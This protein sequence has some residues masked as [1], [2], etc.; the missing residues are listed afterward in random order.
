[1]NYQNVWDQFFLFV[2]LRFGVYLDQIM[3]YMYNVQYIEKIQKEISLKTGLSLTELNKLPFIR[4]EGPP[5]SNLEDCLQLEIHRMTQGEFKKNNNPGGF[6]YDF[7]IENCLS[8]IFNQWDCTK[9]KLGLK[10]KS[11][12]ADDHQIFP[13]MGYMRDL[14][15][16]VQHDLFGERVLTKKDIIE[17][18]ESLTGY[19]FPSFPKGKSITLTDLDVKALVFEIREQAEVYFIPYMNQFIKSC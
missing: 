17:L 18:D 16:R 19:E 9:E 1:M 8:D 15:N 14:R 11:L 5:S 10:K 2:D 4:G 7:S 6:N 3:G 12:N 13:I